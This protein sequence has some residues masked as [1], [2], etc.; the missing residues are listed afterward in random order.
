MK[1]N[2]QTSIFRIAFVLAITCNAAIAQ[3]TS[4]T[5]TTAKADP[6]AYALLKS[7]HDAR[8][9]W[10]ANFAGFTAEFTFNDNGKVSTGS[11]AYAGNTG[12]EIKVEGLAAEASE[13]L[14]NQF[15]SLLAH[16]RGGDFS[17]GDGRHAITFG[18]DDKS[19]LGRLLE[20]HDAMQSS[21]RVRDGQTVEVTRTMNEERFIITVL[22]TQS[23]E[24]SKY[25][26]HNFTVT[27]FDVKT[28]Q[29]KR[30]DMF[31]DSY[32]KKWGVWYPTSRRIIRAE[33]GKLTTRVIEIRNI[34]AKAAGEQAAK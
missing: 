34:R 3:Q 2:L 27:Y 10:P 31:T 19:P 23:V 21:Y 14:N 20:L 25:L 9:T 26:P 15:N 5:A 28:G 6:E 22:N 12:T 16:R 17:K 11:L 1:K 32:E 4:A 33:N 24:G 18:V 8:Q 7:A 13:W 30:S 29:L